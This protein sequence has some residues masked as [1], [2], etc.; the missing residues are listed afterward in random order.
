M[1]FALLIRHSIPVVKPFP[2]ATLRIRW[3]EKLRV[4][5]HSF[6]F[7]GARTVGV[8]GESVILRFNADCEVASKGQLLKLPYD[9][10]IFKHVMVFGEWGGIESAFLAAEIH[11]LLATGFK[12]DRIVFIDMGANVG[13][14]TTQTMKQVP[15]EISCIAIEP[16][17]VL[18]GALSFNLESLIPKA[19]VKILPLAIGEV[20]GTAQFAID[21]QN[22][23]SSSLSVTGSNSTTNQFFD[24]TVLSS[25]DFAKNELSRDQRFILKSDLEGLDCVVLASL[26]D[27]VWMNIF[28]GVVEVT[29]DSK[30]DLSKISI[31]LAQ[32]EKFRF[33]SWEAGMVDLI[34]VADIKDFW[35][36][37]LSE[38][39][40]LYFIK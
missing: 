9:E 5:K 21:H 32:L 37:D 3:F 17:P 39:R 2:F 30:S 24:V 7:G 19:K 16:V 35:E 29:S 22:Y 38:I 12:A 36:S 34:S 20:S 14:V 6:G 33:L 10:M 8:L 15:L 13:L 1:S 11:K 23:G 40:N 26:P 28:A 18:V 25:E 31:L 27:W 4:V